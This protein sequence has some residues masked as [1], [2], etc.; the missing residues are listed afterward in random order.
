MERITING[1][2]NISTFL[3][4][5]RNKANNLRIIKEGNGKPKLSVAKIDREETKVFSKSDIL[6]VTKFLEKYSETMPCRYW[7]PYII[8]VAPVSAW[9]IHNLYIPCFGGYI[10]KCKIGSIKKTTK[11][12]KYYEKVFSLEAIYQDLNDEKKKILI[13]LTRHVIMAMKNKYNL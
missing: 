4:A 11:Y 2:E 10:K 12:N 13:E 1:R 7:L 5:R 8:L 6:D 3:N 9:S